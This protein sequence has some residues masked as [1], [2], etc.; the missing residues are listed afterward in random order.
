MV[1]TPRARLSAIKFLDRRIPKNV[2]LATGTKQS[3]S[4]YSQVIRF[5]KM[6]VEDSQDPQFGGEKPDWYKKE[7]EQAQL[8]AEGDIEA[9]CY[10][11][12]PNREH[13]VINAL[14]KGLSIQDNMDNPVYVNRACFDFLITHLPI[15]SELLS[16]EE[17]IRVLEAALLNLKLR[18]FASHKKFFTWFMGHLDDEEME[19]LADDPA[20]RTIVP[21][22]K[23]IFLRFKN[24]RP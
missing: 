2:K 7:L 5:G 24:V 9:Y 23:R 3:L 1:R 6:R 10:F 12:Y 17:K 22:L 18:D 13:L 4:R 8:L 19:P 16:D 11:Y 20:I 21:A 14:L 15:Q